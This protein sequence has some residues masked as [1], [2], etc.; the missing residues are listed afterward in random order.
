[1]SVILSR[2]RV[3]KIQGVQFFQAVALADGIERRLQEVHVADAGNLHRVL[4]RQEDA[5]ARA[6]FGRQFQQIFAV[7]DNL[8]A[9]HRVQFAARQHLRQRALAGAVRAHDGVHFA[10]IHG[11]VDALQNFAIANRGVQIFNFE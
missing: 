9:G 3:E 10:G 8:A 7:V 1:M 5:V 11:E 4:K 6:V 2:T